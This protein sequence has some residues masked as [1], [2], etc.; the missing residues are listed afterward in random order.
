MPVNP[1]RVQTFLGGLDYPVDK[2]QLI[3]RAREKGADRT[4]LDTLEAMPERTYASPKDVTEAI[5]E[6]FRGEPK[7]RA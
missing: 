1:V 4:V 5:G 7:A 2:A 6:E 3:Q